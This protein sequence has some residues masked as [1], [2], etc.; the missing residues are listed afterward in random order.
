[1]HWAPHFPYE[2]SAQVHKV[3]P[4][5]W[6]SLKSAK[7]NINHYF[8]FL[9]Q[10]A[11]LKKKFQICRTSLTNAF[12]AVITMFYETSFASTGVCGSSSVDT[13]LLTAS[14]ILHIH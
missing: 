14:I 3:E 2:P 13:N 8:V 5:I 9:I 4:L 12:G 6:H 7:K 11:L 10:M 1:M